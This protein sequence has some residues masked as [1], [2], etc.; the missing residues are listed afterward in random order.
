MAT[1]INENKFLTLD[2]GWGC[3]VCWPQQAAACACMCCCCS[4]LCGGLQCIDRG[5]F[6]G[7]GV[8]GKAPIPVYVNVYRLS[9]TL[10]S[11]RYAFFYSYNELSDCAALFGNHEGDIEHITLYIQ[12]DEDMLKPHLRAVY[13]S[14]HGSADSEYQFFPEDGALPADQR[15]RAYIARGGHGIY[16]DTG[17]G[18]CG[19]HPRLFGFG[20]DY[21]A[22]MRETQ[23]S[24][25][26]Y[27]LIGLPLNTQEEWYHWDGIWGRVHSNLCCFDELNGAK[28]LAQKG[29]WTSGQDDTGDMLKSAT[30]LSRLGLR[31]ASVIPRPHGFRFVADVPDA[32]RD[33][34]ALGTSEAAEWPRRFMPRFHF[35][36]SEREFPI[37]FDE[38]Y[39][40]ARKVV[41]KHGLDRTLQNQVNANHHAKIVAAAG[42][43][44]GGGAGAAGAAAAAAAA[45]AAS[46]AGRNNS[47]L[48]SNTGSSGVVRAQPRETELS[49]DDVIVSERHR[50]IVTDV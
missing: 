24:D 3:L 25:S 6:P 2:D 22:A 12:H 20:N 43:G 45:A 14:A 17:V 11:I 34:T 31:K 26:D 49:V 15:V 8:S 10:T 42:G 40:R 38:F 7:A 21:T 35:D 44:A 16:K 28:G 4:C 29:W 27:D 9:S 46:A 13:F 33:L 47:A 50:L 41:F 36:C 37:R 5:T 32:M 39:Q 1:Q 19:C 30:K 18:A 23:F 48:V